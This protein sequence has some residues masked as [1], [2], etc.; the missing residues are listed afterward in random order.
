[1]VTARVTKNLLLVQET[2]KKEVA[3]VKFNIGR[4]GCCN[5][6]NYL[7]LITVYEGARISPKDIQRFLFLN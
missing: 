4:K 1:M 6:S 5:A 7:V 2:M 3:E